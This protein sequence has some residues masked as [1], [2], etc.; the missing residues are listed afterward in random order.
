M[1]KVRYV[2]AF[3]VLMVVVITASIVTYNINYN[4]ELVE[5]K[6]AL[7]DLT[8]SIQHQY[9]TLFMQICFD[10][11]QTITRLNHQGLT[12]EVLLDEARESIYIEDYIIIKDTSEIIGGKNQ[13][14]DLSKARSFF[15]GDEKV[16]CAG[17]I[18]SELDENKFYA[19]NKM[20][21][22]DGSIYL[23]LV[24]LNYDTINELIGPASFYVFNSYP[25]LISGDGYFLYHPDRGVNGQNLYTDKEMI[26]STSSMK[27]KDYQMLLTALKDHSDV[28]HYE[29][30]STEKL[31]YSRAL[32]TFRGTVI[33]AADYSQMKRNQYIAT[34][35]TVMPLVICFMIAMYIFVR[36]I[37]IMKYTDY[38]TEV[39]NHIAFRKHYLTRNTGQDKVIVFEIENI[40]S[41]DDQYSIND[42]SV[43]YKISDYFKG[44]KSMYKEL[45]RISRV[46]YAFVYEGRFEDGINILNAL[47]KDISK[48]N[49]KGIHLKGKVLLLSLDVK[50]PINDIDS[51]LL[52]YMSSYYQPL[53]LKKDRMMHS[54]TRLIQ[55]YKEEID[56]ASMV[57]KMILDNDIEPYF[58]PIVDL[59][60]K[61]PYKYEVLMRPKYSMTLGTGDIV[62]IAEKS[63]WIE[64]ID[65]SM[66]KQAFYLYNKIW[67]EKRKRLK[68]SINL[69]CVSIHEG[70]VDYLVK[71]TKKCDVREEDITIEITETAAFKNLK[72]SIKILQY[73]SRL[74]YRLAIDDFG[75]GYAHVELLSKLPVDYVKVDGVFIRE[76]D[77][78]AQKI[79]TLNALVYL[80]K[81]YNAQVIAE[82]VESNT[83]VKVLE[84]LEVEYGQG[85]YF[86]QPMDVPTLITKYFVKK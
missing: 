66:I 6:E 24:G 60:T 74:G 50:G 7:K 14:V 59:K 8:E 30:Y 75:T 40:L 43:F 79:K 42:D 10:V 20:T 47:K 22:N 80:A 9:D 78:D 18:A 73:L 83:A 65:K 58:Q 41:S 39:S 23:L 45:Y 56:K 38:F 35:R 76:V 54:Y 85:Y 29:A 82:Y 16:L 46:H 28:F 51:C 61:Q 3:V 36:Y 1:I 64:N 4:D 70:V 53:N 25:Y 2:V 67:V 86:D 55:Q 63:G 71:M 49:D 17:M 57:E 32:N 52:N 72:D 11:E 37:Y 31:G 68:L 81:N 19:V 84:K 5:N 21:Q 44:M 48:G 13:A 34:L 12:K 26:L 27:E 62:S 33:L 77:K 15:F 69:S